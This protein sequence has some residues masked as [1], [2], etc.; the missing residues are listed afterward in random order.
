MANKMSEV[1]IPVFDGEDYA[2]WKKRIRMFC[3]MKK[4][5]EVLARAK[6]AQDKDEWDDKDISA[7]NYIY[8]AISNRQLEFIGDKETAYEIMQKFDELYLREY[9]KKE[10]GKT[11]AE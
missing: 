4:C 3:R 11:T 8:S 9:G 7:I 6:T 2:S 1:T 10:T 5:D